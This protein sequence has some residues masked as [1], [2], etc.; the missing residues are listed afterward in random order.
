LQHEDR[1][2]KLFNLQSH[3]S[4][5]KKQRNLS[6]TQKTLRQ[7]TPGFVNKVVKRLVSHCLFAFASS[8]NLKIFSACNGERDANEML[9]ELEG[10]KLTDPGF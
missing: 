4:C 5:K 10:V 8:S 1:K 9:L 7:V 6:H 2:P 3:I